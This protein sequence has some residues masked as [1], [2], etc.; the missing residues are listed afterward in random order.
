MFGNPDELDRLARQLNDRATDLR[1]HALAMVNRAQA[2]HWIS[3]AAE[4]YRHVVLDD[5]KRLDHC[6]DG[7]DAAAAK[8]R[9]HAQTVRERIAEIRRIEQAVTH[10]F[11]N[12]VTSL[13]GAVLHA[14]ESVAGSVVD[15]IGGLFDSSPPPVWHDWPFT[16]DNLPAPDSADWLQAGDFFRKV[17]VL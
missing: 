8:L 14:A 5:R 3:P 15:T 13:P 7:L 11:A 10:F 9:E 6:A 4:G 2:M 16:P 17:G 12:A 1:D